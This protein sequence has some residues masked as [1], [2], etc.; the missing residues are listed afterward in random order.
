MKQLHQALSDYQIPQKRAPKFCDEAHGWPVEGPGFNH[1]YFLD[2]ARG[3]GY[4]QF[5]RNGTGNTELDGPMFQLTIKQPPVIPVFKV[6]NNLR[7]LD[8][9]W[10]PVE[11]HAENHK[12]EAKYARQRAETHTGVFMSISKGSPVPHVVYSKPQHRGTVPQACATPICCHR[13]SAVEVPQ[14]S[15]GILKMSQSAGKEQALL[16]NSTK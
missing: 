11:Q 12:T 8:Q 2:K 16:L 13:T 6:K 9:F 1:R 5:R 3:K 10:G 15:K 4:L 7:G 14:R